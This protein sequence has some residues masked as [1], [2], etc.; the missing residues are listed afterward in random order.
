MRDPPAHEND[1]YRE[2]IV[3]YLLPK[4]L[5]KKHLFALGLALLSYYAQATVQDDSTPS[6][7]IGAKVFAQRCVLCHG[8]Q[9]MGEGIIPLKIAGY[10]NT[11]LLVSNKTVTKQ[12]IHQVV[13][14]GAML[15]QISIYMPPMGNELTWTEL[16]SVALFVYNFRRDPATYLKILSSGQQEP[17]SLIQKCRGQR[18]FQSRCALCHGVNGEGNGRMAKI[19]QN[20]PPFNLTRSIQPASYLKR[21]ISK[22]GAALNRSER[23]PAWQNQ[24]SDSDIDAVVKYVMS[25]RTGD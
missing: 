1:G 13:A 23:M 21:I 9:G 19:I 15:P 22:G 12:Q 7:D 10:P 5:M 16:E 11:N 6:I 18:I 4:R 14:S 20:P 8:P 2:V 17:G 3:A 24:L 25:L